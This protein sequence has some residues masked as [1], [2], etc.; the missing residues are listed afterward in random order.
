MPV[1][2]FRMRYRTILALLLAFTT[3][4]CQKAFMAEDNMATAQ[5]YTLYI[6]GTV[7]D[8]DT[9]LPL[10]GIKLT[11]NAYISSEGPISELSKAVYSDSKGAYQLS[12]EELQTP[13]RYTITADDPNSGYNSHSG[14]ISVNPDGPSFINNSFYI[15]DF[16]IWLK[17]KN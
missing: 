13:V 6:S 9:S 11:F 4:S 8:I 12:I 16:N 7:S 5:P 15:N 14:E 1:K 3:L 2:Q 10:E 17:K